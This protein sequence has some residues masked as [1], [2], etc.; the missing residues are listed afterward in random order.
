MFISLLYGNYLQKYS[1]GFRF[2]A[3]KTKNMLKGRRILITGGGSGIGKA[4]AAQLSHH[5]TVLICGRNESKLK[6]VAN[7]YKNIRYYVADIARPGEIDRLFNRIANDNI[8]LDVLFNNAAVVEQF[9][10]TRTNFTSEQIFDR[11]NTNLSAG[12]AVVQQFIKQANKQTE[13]LIVNVTSEIALFPIPL[14]GL[15]SSSKAGFSVF[16]KLLRQQ[17]KNTN[18]T[19]IEVLP[20]QVETDMPKQIG[21][22]A[23]GMSAEVFAVKTIKSIEQGKKE[24]APGSFVPLLKL[25]SKFLPGFGLNLVDKL[26]K[27][28]LQV[29]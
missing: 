1:R 2:A 24:F 26:S 20:P 29:Q 8:V 5:N 10:V 18:F 9:D 28:Q 22:T 25:F 27:K 14:L 21:N 15:Y 3:L 17:L 23:K 19:V 12:I 6:D 4:L 13:N 7:T 11:I 16:T